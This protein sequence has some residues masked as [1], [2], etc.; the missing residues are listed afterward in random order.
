[1]SI[2]EQKAL[3]R[4]WRIAA[5]KGNLLWQKSFWSII[6]LFK[7]VTTIWWLIFQRLSP[8][9]AWNYFVVANENQTKKHVFRKTL[10]LLDKAIWF[11]KQNFGW[12]SSRIPL[13][14][15]FSDRNVGEIS[16]PDGRYKICMADTKYVLTFAKSDDQ[17]IPSDFNLV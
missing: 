7:Y 5:A 1:M 12:N 17:R 13:S 2:L 4:Q 9:K 10:N 8:L 11:A 3:M 6:W 15:N 14:Y 16:P